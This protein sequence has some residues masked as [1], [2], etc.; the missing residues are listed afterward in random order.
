[1][2]FLL[3]LALLGQVTVPGPPGVTLEKLWD[4]SVQ[5][6]G[7]TEPLT[8]DAGAPVACGDGSAGPRRRAF[9]PTRR[10]R[11]DASL[12][13]GAAVRSEITPGTVQYC[14]CH[15]AHVK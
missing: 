8:L 1:M 4:I 2:E 6:P 13:V 7:T 3:T 10:R 11:P 14:Q 5:L 9:A 12:H 15:L